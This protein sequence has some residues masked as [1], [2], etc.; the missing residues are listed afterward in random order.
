MIVS[1]VCFLYSNT[2]TSDINVTARPAT[3]HEFRETIDSY[4]SNLDANN[5][6]ALE[7][8]ISPNMRNWYGIKNPSVLEVKQNIRDY[9]NKYPFTKTTV[10]WSKLQVVEEDNGEYT[11]TYPME[12]KVKSNMDSPYRVYDL[13]ILTIWDKEY[14]LI[15]AQEERR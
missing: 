9:R 10:D 1:V 4:Y 3:A 14:K 15:S 13:N 8:Y 6:E 2:T 7:N 5:L 11:V 12:Y